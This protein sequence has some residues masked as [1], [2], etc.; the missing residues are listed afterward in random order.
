MPRSE[1]LSYEEMMRLVR[2]VV[3][4]GVKKLRI[5]G[6]EPFIRKDLMSFLRE[7]AS[8]S[9]LDQLHITTNGTLTGKLIPDLV[10][11]GIKSVNLSLDSL[12]RDR[13]FKITRRDE[14]NKV[15]ETMDQLIN[16]GISTKIN[17]VVMDGR[18]IE[19]IYPMIELSI[20]KNVAVRF[21][22]EMP[23]NGSEGQVVS[24]QWNYKR[25][26]DHISH[27]FEHIEKLDDPKYSTSMN[28]KIK[29]AQGSFGVI[30]A[31][32]RTFCGT[33]NRLRVTPQGVLKTCLYD[34]G[35]FNLKT[36]MRNGAS[37]QELK[38]A[39]N[40]AV[41][42]KDLNGFEA[43]KNRFKGFPVSESMSTIGG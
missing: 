43:E 20:R 41:K 29:G 7:V 37:D 15:I 21:I 17:M 25:I 16:H 24:S 2:I 27:R 3:D 33:C 22:E 14:F 26:L 23:F 35:V 30:A 11:L 28:Y 19:D 10:K 1:L 12:D 18:N 39:I 4:M 36:F 13:F 5:T 32:S 8:L 6:G 34:S 40:D 38:S 31:Y 9:G 42:H